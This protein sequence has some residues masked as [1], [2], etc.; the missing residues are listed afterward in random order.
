MLSRVGM[1][2]SFAI[3]ASL[4]SGIVAV[5]STAGPTVIAAAPARATS[6][7]GSADDAGRV[8]SDGGGPVLAGDPAAPDVTPPASSSDARAVARFWAAAAASGG[9]PAT[10][11][12]GQPVASGSGAAPSTPHQ[13]S[14]GPRPVSKPPTSPPSNPPTNPPPSTSP[15]TAPSA[16]PPPYNCSGS[17]DGM[18][19]A[20]KHARE[21]YCQGGGE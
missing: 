15:T 13:P 10:N 19:E 20:Y 1:A 21:Q 8:R 3:A 7:G 16:S 2:S 12:A 18:T 9:H 11:G 4:L 5:A 17:D 14:S 6:P